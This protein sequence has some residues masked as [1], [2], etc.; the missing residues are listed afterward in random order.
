[1]GLQRVGRD[2]HFHF[3]LSSYNEEVVVCR[4][5]ENEKQKQG[6]GCML[7][8]ELTGGTKGLDLG[9]EKKE[10]SEMKEQSCH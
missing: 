5:R 4:I 3:S 8:V 9:C 6:S 7:K 1:M 2:F 10:K